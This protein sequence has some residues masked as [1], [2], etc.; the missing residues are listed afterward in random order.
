MATISES[1]IASYDGSW[2]Y[3]KDKLTDINNVEQTVAEINAINVTYKNKPV[4]DFI[5]KNY[6]CSLLFKLR[7][8]TELRNQYSIYLKEILDR[9]KKNAQS[10]KSTALLNTKLKDLSWP[11]IIKYKNEIVKNDTIAYDIKLLIRLYTEVECPVRND[12]IGLRVFIDEP[13]PADMIGNCLM[14][15]KTPLKKRKRKFI[16]KKSVSIDDDICTDP[17]AVIYPVRNLMWLNKFKSSKH[18]H[19]KD[20]IQSIPIELANDIISYCEKNNTRVLFDYC[21]YIIS[22]KITSAFQIVSKRNIGIN[23]MRH[24]YIMYFMKDAPMLDKRANIAEK[25]GHT[26]SIQELYRLH[27]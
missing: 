26:I 7:D 27:I 21:D 15:T 9:I 6:F 23:V 22:K 14:L 3:I 20:I 13:R 19:I 12:F 4:T 1:T 10:Q 11:D 5:R 25:M 24:L 16:V 2:K 17:D 18:T 8:N